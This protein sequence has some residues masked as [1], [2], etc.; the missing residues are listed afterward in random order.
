MARIPRSPTYAAPTAAEYRPGLI[1]PSK[2]AADPSTPIAQ[3]HETGLAPWPTV[4]RYPLLI[5]PN[6]SLEYVAACYRV[7]LTGYRMMWVDLLD[8][9]LQ[10]EPHGY[11]VLWKRI[12][13]VAGARLT[14]ERPEYIADDDPDCEKAEAIR[15]FVERQIKQI[16]RLRQHIAFLAWASYYA[17]TGLGDPLGARRRPLGDRASLVR[18][19]TTIQLP[20]SLRVGPLHLGPGASPR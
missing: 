5:G 1:P 14:V 13:G 11:G 4:D 19:L 9:M 15:S 6:L 2:Q 16:P 8:E 7:C 20:G 3:S 10:K 18:P 12:L 17:V